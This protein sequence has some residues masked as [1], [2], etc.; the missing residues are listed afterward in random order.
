MRKTKTVTIEGGEGNRDAGKKFVI[1]EMAAVPGER[2]ATRALLAMGRAGIEMPDDVAATGMAGFVV[3]GLRGLLSVPFE[4]AEPL[5]AE[6]MGCVQYM[7]NPTKPNVLRATIDDDFEEI[8]TILKLRSEVI[9][10]HVGFSIAATLS[11]IG[12]AAMGETDPSLSPPPTSP[13]ASPTS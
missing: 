8:T 9:D 12:R 2:W 13:E 7:P 4:E 5:L 11:N 10:L 3:M 6:M 1:T